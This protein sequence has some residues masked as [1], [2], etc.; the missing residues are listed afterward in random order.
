MT[1][2]IS[3]KT[4]GTLPILLS[5]PTTINSGQPRDPEHNSFKLDSTD[6]NA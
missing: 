6:F 3:H 4:A 5:N 2:Y 1:K